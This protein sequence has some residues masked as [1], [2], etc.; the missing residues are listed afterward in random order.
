MAATPETTAEIPRL[1]DEAIQAALT[2]HSGP[3]FIDFPLDHVFM[4]AAEPDLPASVPRSTVPAPDGRALQRAA[5]LLRAPRSWPAPGCTG[6][7]E[8]LRALAE[9]LRSR[10][11]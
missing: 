6:G 4:S 2:P 9:R 8:Q 3:A 1:I 11:S 10:C 5:A 7:E